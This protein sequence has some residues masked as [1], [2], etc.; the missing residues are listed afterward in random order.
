MLTLRLDV[1]DLASVR[2]GYSPIQ[3]T[4]QSMWALRHPDRHPLHQRWR[5][6]AIPLLRHFD[7]P[8]LNSLEGPRG[9]IPDFL[10]PYPETNIPAF[11]DELATLRR[12]EP[13]RVRH[14]IHAAY[15]DH[16][17]RLGQLPAALDAL[18]RDPASL[19]DAIADAVSS[20]W[21]LLIAPYWPQLRDVLDGDIDHRARQLASAGAGEL[22][23]GLDNHL[24]WQDGRLELDAAGLDAIA[25]IDGRGLMLTPSVFENSVNSMIDERLPPVLCYAARGRARLWSAA[26]P[27]GA[28]LAALLGA[29]RAALLVELSEPATTTQLA[30]RLSLTPGGVSQHLRVLHHSG[31]VRRTRTGRVVNYQR[32]TVGDQLLRAASSIHP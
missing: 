17:G 10:T 31:L 13:D 8:L 1:T 24:R 2:F 14:D 9:W 19:R 18:D 6:A 28:E 21:E 12:T 23:S 27:A 3:E 29:T 20:Y 22:F 11:G 25:D 4:V 7:W 26:R 32:S 5:E 15:V 30:V 16:D